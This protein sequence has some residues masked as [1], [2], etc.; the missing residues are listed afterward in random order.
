MKVDRNELKAEM[1]FAVCLE[2]K[3]LDA[4]RKIYTTERVKKELKY[5]NEELRQYE[6]EEVKAMGKKNKMSYVRALIK[7]RKTIRNRYQSHDLWQESVREKM[8][9]RYEAGR[10]TTFDFSGTRQKRELDKD[11]VAVQE[12][13]YDTDLEDALFG[14]SAMF[15]AKGFVGGVYGD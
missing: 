13:I 11:D 15:A 10:K 1:D 5:L 12:S 4:D 2:E 8:K 3:K 9:Q 14:M 7:A 6:L